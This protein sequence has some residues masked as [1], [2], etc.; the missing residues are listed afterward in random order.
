MAS[1]AAVAAGRG[2]YAVADWRAPATA[3]RARPPAT[4]AITPRAT[5]ARHRCLSSARAQ[6]RIAEAAPPVF[7]IATILAEPTIRGNRVGTTRRGPGATTR[8]GPRPRSP[9][10]AGYGS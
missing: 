4:P 10:R 1:G 7:P 2:L 9:L 8:P 5:S 6:K 3:A